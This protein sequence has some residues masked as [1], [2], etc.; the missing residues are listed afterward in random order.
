MNTELKAIIDA[1]VDVEGAV[2]DAVGK[3]AFASVTMPA[4]MKVGMDMPNVISNWS[5]LQAE[6]AALSVPANQQDLEA[7]VLSKV[8]GATPKA[9]AII[10]SAV[11]LVNGALQLVTALKMA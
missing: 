10:A 3:A 4:L 7:Y 2:V 5:D 6:V 1:L 9:Q 11:T 8:S